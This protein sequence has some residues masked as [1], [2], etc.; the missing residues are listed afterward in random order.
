[1][2]N[3]LLFVLFVTIFSTLLLSVPQYSISDPTTLNCPYEFDNIVY[4]AERDTLVHFYNSEFENGFF[5]IYHF[6]LN[7]N[8]QFSQE[9]LISFEDLPHS[10]YEVKYKRIHNTNSF[11][12]F[13]YISNNLMAIAK[14]LDFDY[15]DS[16]VNIAQLDSELIYNVSPNSDLLFFRKNFQGEEYLDRWTEFYVYEFSSCQLEFWGMRQDRNQMMYSLDDLFISFGSNTDESYIGYTV[17][18]SQLE[19]DYQFYPDYNNIDFSVLYY[20][21]TEQSILGG[22]GYFWVKPPIYLEVTSSELY[23]F[24]TSNDDL[25]SSW[26]SYT[27]SNCLE[28]VRVDKY[29]NIFHAG[30]QY[31]P[32]DYYISTLELIGNQWMQ[33][34]SIQERDFVWVSDRIGKGC[35][36]FDGLLVIPVHTESYGYGFRVYDED[37]NNVYEHP[38]EFMFGSGYGR[39]MLKVFNKIF[40]AHSQSDILKLY[41]FTNNT[42]NSDSELPKFTLMTA[43]NYPN[44]FNPTTTIE[45]NIPKSGDVEVSI[46]NLK[47]ELVNNII[48]E[49]KIKG[50]HSVV[51]DGT[52]NSDI[53]VSSGIYFCKVESKYRRVIL[54]IALI[55]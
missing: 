23:F 19:I 33:T 20:E 13:F 22:F 52:D 2:K 49:F 51:W 12:L 7:E 46:Y 54:R 32:S 26:V 48:S 29:F 41:S 38:A 42:P 21:G 14:V 10:N 28:P 4:D 55:K 16:T 37:L 47:G 11:H 44:P 15:F 25:V 40:L 5:N 35:L 1:M 39:M 36:S 31:D 8:M 27:L 24:D 45:Y 50:K 3:L 17:Y 6:T 43:S 18:N 9:S 30:D 53:E 34:Q